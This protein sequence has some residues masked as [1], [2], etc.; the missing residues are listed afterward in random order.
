MKGSTVAG[1]AIISGWSGGIGV[2]LW[3]AWKEAKR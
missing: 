2:P 1:L 3:L